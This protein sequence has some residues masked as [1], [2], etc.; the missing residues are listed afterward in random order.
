MSTPAAVRA[1]CDAA[2]HR[3]LLTTAAAERLRRYA[4]EQAIT[5]LAGLAAWLPTADS[6]RGDLATRLAA[7]LVPPSATLCGTWRLLAHLTDGGMGRVYL[8]TPAARADGE[9][10]VVKRI[11]PQPGDAQAKEE[12]VRRFAREARITRTL[13]H[14]NIVRFLD[15]G[16]QEDG[17]VFLVLEYIASGDLKALLAGRPGLSEP[18]ALAIVHQVVDALGAAHQLH[19]V[20]RDIKPSNIFVS[21]DGKALLADFGVACTTL[22]EGTSLTLPG[23]TVG[24][25]HY[26]APEQ[27][28]GQEVTIRSDLYAVGAV[29]FYAL[30]GRPPFEGPVQDILHQ[31]CHVPAPD[32]RALRAG[33]S[34]RTAQVVATCLAK[35]PQDRPADPAALARQ[36]EEALANLGV[37]L[38]QAMSTGAPSATAQEDEPKPLTTMPGFDPG[39][40]APRGAGRSGEDTIIA[41][42]SGREDLAIEAGTSAGGTDAVV[43]TAIRTLTASLLATQAPPE[44]PPAPGT[45]RHVVQRGESGSHPG[46]GSATP[47]SSGSGT[48]RPQHAR[49]EGDPASALAGDWLT[50]Q[51]PHPGEP[52]QVLLFARPRLVLGKLRDQPVDLCLRNYPIQAHKDGLLRISRSHVQLTY[53]RV[54]GCLLAEDLGG[55]NGTLLDGVPLP[56]RSPRALTGTEAHVLVAASAVALWLRL[57]PRRRGGRILV[58]GLPPEAQPSCG[59]ECDLPHDAVLITR[60]ENRPEAAYAMVLARLTIGGPGADLPLVGARSLSAVVIARAGGRWIWQPAG[61]EA[62]SPL[63]AGTVLDCGGLQLRAEPGSYEHFGG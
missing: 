50:L 40:L 46:S 26:M 39:P 2:V 43:A 45:G 58:D 47:A 19:L 61:A 27:A 52:T 41:D 3:H 1:L 59:L 37:S 31:H 21:S 28:L 42:L 36:L 49:L 34:A 24:S 17:T 56:A 54:Q 13:V 9:L 62:W 29:L 44:R 60:P 7:L 32:V 63:A 20:H 11:K 35:R 16:V 48:D 25:P 53:D 14:P 12:R 4:R 5:D 22:R 6:I 15:S 8:A 10:V 38:R 18:L 33:V 23:A 30:T 55:A 51:P 57:R